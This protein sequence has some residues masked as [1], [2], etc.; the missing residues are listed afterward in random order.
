MASKQPLD[1]RQ[2]GQYVTTRA[3]IKGYDL[4]T[5]DGRSRLAKDTGLPAN[6]ITAIAAGKYKPSVDPW[7]TFG[8]ILGERHKDMLCMAGILEPSGT[9]PEGRASRRPLPTWA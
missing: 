7:K 2:F 6:D 8:E 9:R 1:P 5:A 3:R 4:D